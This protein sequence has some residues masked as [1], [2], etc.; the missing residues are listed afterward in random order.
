[1]PTIRADS[2]R[3]TIS[4]PDNPDGFIEVGRIIAG[5]TFSPKFNVSYGLELEYQESSEHRR[6]EGGSLRTIGDDSLARRLPINL[7]WLEA[8]DRRRMSDELLR[9]G[10]RGDIYISVFPESGGLD[11]AEYAFMA[12]RENNHAHTHDFYANWSSHPVFVEV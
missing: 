10:K 11:E 7:D 1:M 6:T 2:Y 12:R 5:E 9:I 4:D 8:P 3:I